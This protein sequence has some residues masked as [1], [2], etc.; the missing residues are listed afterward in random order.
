MSDRPDGAGSDES[1]PAQKSTLGSRRADFDAR[2]QAARHDIETQLRAGKARLDSRNE[3]L[4]ARTGRNLPAA[5]AVGVLLGAAVLLSLIFVKAFF[6][7]VAAALIGSLCFELASALRFAG[8]DVPRLPSVLAG[9]AVVPAAFY[10]GAAGHWAALL[11]GIVFVSAWRLVELAR[12]SHRSSASSLG[13]DLGAGAFVQIYCAFLGSFMVLM[14][15]RPDGQWWTLSALIVVIAVDTG[16]Y[17]T[18]LNFGKHPM[19]PRISPKKTWEGFAGSVAASLIAAVLLSVF[20]LDEPWW[21]GLVFGGVIIV[22]ATIGDL[23]ESLIKRD[24]GIKDI[25]TWLPGHGGFL[26]R[27]DST[28]PSAAAAYGLY[29]LFA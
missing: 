11:G 25:S 1:S 27:L 8:R 18:G 2:A 10:G 9:V 22:T 26:D 19:A 23:S 5:I 20:L 28:L 21:F 29:L 6:M 17:A 7:I 24:L 14:A 12:P 4:T 3:K 13:R 15:A 16:A